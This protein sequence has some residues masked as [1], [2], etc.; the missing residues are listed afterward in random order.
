MDRRGTTG[1]GA[2][3]GAARRATNPGRPLHGGPINGNTATDVYSD[4]RT[5]S[6]CR[7]ERHSRGHDGRADTDQPSCHR[8]T[9]QSTTYTQ[10]DANAVPDQ[11]IIR[12]TASTF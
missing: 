3:L 7:R 4:T 1:G 12:V 8:G 6:D 9:N 10:H 11:I 2:N 5:D